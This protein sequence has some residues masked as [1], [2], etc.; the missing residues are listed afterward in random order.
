MHAPDVFYVDGVDEPDCVSSYL[1]HDGVDE[2][3]PIAELCSVCPYDSYESPVDFFV[4]GFD[5][6]EKIEENCHAF[7]PPGPPFVFHEKF[8]DLLVESL[9]GVVAVRVGYKDWNQKALERP[10]WFIKRPRLAAL[11]VQAVCQRARD[12]D[13]NEFPRCS[14]CGRMRIRWYEVSDRIADIQLHLGS[15]PGTDIFLV[16]GG[17]QGCGVF[18]TSVGIR[19]LQSLGFW[20]IRTRQVEWY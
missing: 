14:I 16:E 3:G 11:H 20:T 7:I 6:L 5:D 12:P 19:K 2:R 15:W 1:I 9:S 13:G 17:H 10:L 4:K 18:V 8:T